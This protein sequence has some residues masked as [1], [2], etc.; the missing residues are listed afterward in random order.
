MTLKLGEYN[1]ATLDHLI[2]RSQKGPTND[3]NLVAACHADN[4]LK[5]KRPAAA[6]IPLLER[7][8]PL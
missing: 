4:Q 1:T 3:F 8:D 7:V 5:G 2:P 6:M